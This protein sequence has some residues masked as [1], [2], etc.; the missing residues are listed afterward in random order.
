[1]NV[2]FTGKE[3]KG[4]LVSMPAGVQRVEQRASG[5]LLTASSNFEP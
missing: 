5:L 2:P 4:D 3:Q 1:M